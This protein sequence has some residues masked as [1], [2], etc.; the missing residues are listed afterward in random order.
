MKRSFSRVAIVN[1][2]EAALRFVHA[3]LELNREGERLHTIALYTEPER[4]AL[5]VREADEAWDLGTRTAG[6]RR[7]DRRKAAGGRPRDPR[8][9]VGGGARGERGRGG[10]AGGRP[11]L[12]GRGE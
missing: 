10:A 1:R 11:R 5:F 4:H 3:A 7:Q 2:G 9:P 6:P 8:G 12:S